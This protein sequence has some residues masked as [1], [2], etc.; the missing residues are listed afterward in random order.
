MSKKKIP[1]WRYNP[2]RKKSNPLIMHSQN[3]TCLHLES[4]LNTQIKFFKDFTPLS[5]WLN[6]FNVYHCL[7][8][9]S[10]FFFMWFVKPMADVVLLSLYSLMYKILISYFFQASASKGLTVLEKWTGA[11]PRQ[12]Y[13]YLVTR[14]DS[15]TFSWAFQKVKQII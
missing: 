5:N 10:S 13:S 8:F 14:N 12:Y 15:Y 7:V 6:Y 1:V 4:S 9:L 2:P 11:Q 3:Y